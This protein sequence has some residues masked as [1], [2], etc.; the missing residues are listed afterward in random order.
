MNV[1]K[2]MFG[3]SYIVATCSDYDAYQRLE[4]VTFHDADSA[5]RFIVGLNVSHGFWER[6]FNTL[7]FSNPNVRHHTDV[8]NHISVMLAHRKFYIFELPENALNAPSTSSRTIKGKFNESFV[9]LSSGESALNKVRP[10][11]SFASEKEAE[12]FVNS[13]DI[14]YKQLSAVVAT[15]PQA[16]VSSYS[17]SEKKQALIKALVSQNIVIQKASSRGPSAK[18]VE[19]EDQVQNSPGNRQVN[20][21]PEAD[22]APPPPPKKEKLDRDAEQAA[23]LVMAAES[24]DAFCEDCAAEASQG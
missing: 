15:L 14:S 21:L 23:T 12:V 13:L 3:K 19:L 17:E 10:S 8:L 1:V 11:R 16:N 20:A 18:G 22:R 2:N 4:Q 7:G 6:I 5:R 24:G 9:F